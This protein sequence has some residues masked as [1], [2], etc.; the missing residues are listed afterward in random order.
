MIRI[1]QLKLGIDEP[2]ETLSKL[3]AKKLKLKPTDIIDYH[4]FKESIDARRGTVTFA[5]TVDVTVL[6]ESSLL[7]KGL[8]NVAKTPVLEYVGP[9]RLEKAPEEP[10]IVIG[11]G[12]AGMYA[13]LLLAQSGYNPIV[14]ERGGSVESRAESVAKFWDEAVL[15]PESNVQFGEG[16]AGTFSDGKLTTR[17]KDLRGRKVLEELVDAGAPA[18]ILYEAHPHVGTDLLRG[19]VANIRKKIIALGGQVHFDTRVDSL[20][21]EDGQICGVITNKNETFKSKNVVLAVGHSARDAFEMLYHHGV[22]MV[23]KPFAIGMRIEH[24]QTL[25]NKAQYKEFA[26][27]PRLGAAEYRLTHQTS[28]GRGVYTFCMCP[29]GF[30]VPAATEANMVVT[31]GMSE[32]D[33]AQKNANS[34][35]LVQVSTDDFESD[36]PL[37]GI[38]FQRDLERKAFALGGSN[39]QAP[40]QLVGDFLA[41]RPSASFGAVKPSYFIGGKLTNLRPLFPSSLVESFV[42]GLSAL[43]QKLNGFAADDAVLTGIETRSSSPVRILRDQETLESTNISGFYPAGEGAGFA[44]G[45]VSSAIDGIKCAEMLMQNFK[46]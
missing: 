44:G 3:I 21:I 19:V 23:A 26:E 35:L 13:A 6:D 2:V 1:S 39:Y 5:Y 29:G 30:V 32:H 8:P 45:I 9:A 15:D 27:H 37:A 16:G 34:A 7:A 10:P 46:V 25:I 41:D 38:K 43:D 4:I 20:I 14:L 40:M 11:F 42:E 28:N 12:P 36:H 17:V 33:R 31:N 18:D 24:P 22:D